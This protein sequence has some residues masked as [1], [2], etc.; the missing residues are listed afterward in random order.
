MTGRTLRRRAVSRW[1]RT[2][3]RCSRPDARRLRV[4]SLNPYNLLEVG[5]QVYRGHLE[6]VAAASGHI[7]TVNVLGVEDYLRGV[8]PYELGTVDRTAL[9]A[10]KAMAIAART[11]ACKRMLA[12]A[13]GTSTSTATCR[14]R[15]TRA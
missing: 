9:E 11:Y 10:L 4:V 13:P 5:G 2:T 6:I 8:L 12:R 15:C 7:S 14:T 3:A 1:S